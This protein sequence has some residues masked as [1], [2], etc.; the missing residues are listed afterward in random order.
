MTVPVL[1]EPAPQ[2]ARLLNVALENQH[3]LH[4]GMTLVACA[5]L[6]PVEALGLAWTQV[7]DDGLVLQLPDRDVPI[8]DRFVELF[9]WHGCRQRHDARTAGFRWDRYGH[10]VT[11]NQGRPYSLREADEITSR[12]AMEVGLPPMP[13]A[14]LRRPAWQ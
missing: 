5:R 12:F 6:T 1:Q 4:I 11:D 2:V 3:R 7:D 14:A 9:Y 13:M 10:V 8:N